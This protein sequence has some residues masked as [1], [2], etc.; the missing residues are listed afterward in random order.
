MKKFQSRTLKLLKPIAQTVSILFLITLN[1]ITYINLQ[2]S[3][4]TLTSNSFSIPIASNYRETSAVVIQVNITYRVES[5][6]GYLNF[7]RFWTHRL[8][9]HNNSTQIGVAPIQESE[10]LSLDYNLMNATH[11]ID[12]GDVNNNIVEYFGFNLTKNQKFKYTAIYRV[13]LAE[14]K[15]Q[16]END[17]SE[18]TEGNFL[19]AYEQHGVNISSP[20]YQHLTQSENNLEANNS[21]LVSLTYEICEGKSTLQEKIQAILLWLR[22]NIAAEP[23]DRSQGAYQTYLRGIGDCSDYATLFVTMLRILKVPARKITGLQFLHIPDSFYPLRVGESFKY[24]GAKIDSYQYY[25]LFPGHAWAEYYHPDCGFISLDPTFA[26][27]NPQKYTNYIGYYYLTSNIGENYYEGIEPQLPYPYTGWGM[28][29]Y[30]KAASTSSLRW[31]YT[32]EAVVEETMGYV[33]IPKFLYL[34]RGLFVTVPIS[35]LVFLIYRYWKKSKK[36]E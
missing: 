2:T 11:K 1:A 20:W 3:L 30:I 5:V 16:I 12:Y 31:N 15:W 7:I 25:A 35:G 34:I 8:E 9:S 36:N 29:P 24:S 28:L 17:I 23:T 19:D 6:G 27:T 4:S 32:V 14:L 33:W 26:R 10:L 22:D 13:R 21:E 18:N